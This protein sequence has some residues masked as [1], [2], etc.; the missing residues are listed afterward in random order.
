MNLQVRPG[1]SKSKNSQKHKHMHTQCRA[2]NSIS[3]EILVIEQESQVL[4]DECLC[5]LWGYLLKAFFQWSIDLIQSLWLRDFRRWVGLGRRSKHPAG[6]AGLPAE[7]WS[8]EHWEV[9]ATSVSIG[10]YY[11]QRYSA[12]NPTSAW[13]KSITSSIIITLSACIVFLFPCIFM[14]YCF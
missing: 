13:S 5:V 2:F 1:K 14:L 12:P 4:V 3:E 8:A 9:P 7:T 11:R 6:S 10:Q